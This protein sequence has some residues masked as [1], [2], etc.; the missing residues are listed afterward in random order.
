MAAAPQPAARRHGRSRGN[1]HLGAPL[2]D[3]VAPQHRPATMS[4]N[5]GTSLGTARPDRRRRRGPHRRPPSAAIASPTTRTQVP[6]R[7]REEIAEGRLRRGRAPRGEL[8]QRRF[9]G[10]DLVGHVGPAPTAEG[11]RVPH[12][13]WGDGRPLLRR[14]RHPK[15]HQRQ[16]ITAAPAA[17]P[18][19]REQRPT[20]LALLVSSIKKTHFGFLMHMLLR[21]IH[22]IMFS[23]NELVI[24]YE[25]K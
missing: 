6:A 8:G 5:G 20:L 7:H 17:S 9:L 1:R 13:L 11:P 3:G 22:S 4:Q 2:Q 19:S 18:G 14:R 10:V 15:R 21:E 16:G 25:E 24:Y 23:F 12:R